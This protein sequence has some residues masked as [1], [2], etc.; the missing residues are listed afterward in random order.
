MQEIVG[1]AQAQLRGGLSVRV[2]IT[3]DESTSASTPSS[4]NADLDEGMK[5]SPTTTFHGGR[6]V[7][8]QIVRSICSGTSGRVAIA[9]MCLRYMLFRTVLNLP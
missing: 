4:D 2:H 1:G 5:G 3:G 8:R 6:P 9:G 7:L